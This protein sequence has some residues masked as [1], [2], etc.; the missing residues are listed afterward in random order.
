MDESEIDS[1][2][3]ENKKLRNYISLIS[4]EVELSQRLHEIKQNFSDSPD[5][6]RLTVPILDRITRIKSEKSILENDLN[7][8]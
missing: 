3:S 4:A 8:D 6:K 7:L 5:S 2:K 1:I